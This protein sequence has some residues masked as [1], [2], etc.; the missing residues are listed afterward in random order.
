MNNEQHENTN[1]AEDAKRPTHKRLVM[2]GAR[3]PLETESSLIQ[4]ALVRR[5]RD[6]DGW[7]GV[8]EAWEALLKVQRVSKDMFDEHERFSK[9]YADMTSS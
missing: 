5:I 9:C 6:A 8:K 3:T 1:T 2:N 4:E 7:Q